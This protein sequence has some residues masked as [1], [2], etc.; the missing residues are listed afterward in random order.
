MSNYAFDYPTGRIVEPDPPSWAFGREFM[1]ATPEAV[2][3]CR[4]A[5]FR[6]SI[7]DEVDFERTTRKKFFVKGEDEYF[8]YHGGTL[9]CAGDAGVTAFYV[10]PP[11]YL[12]LLERPGSERVKS[13]R[14]G[15]LPR[16]YEASPDLR[17][18]PNWEPS[19][20]LPEPHR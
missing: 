8:R 2:A 14:L 12:V 7:E 16:G 17:I 18:R 4:D 9:E 6:E 19:M 20:P 3:M 13:E 5:G 1:T 10:Q 15:D 11:G